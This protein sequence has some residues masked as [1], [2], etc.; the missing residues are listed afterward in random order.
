MTHENSTSAAA[1]ES[2]PP[3]ADQVAATGAT[4]ART[5]VAQPSTYSSS[6]APTVHEQHY[7]GIDEDGL[8]RLVVL[9][10]FEQYVQLNQRLDDIVRLVAATATSS[11]SAS[12]SASADAD[13]NPGSSSSSNNTVAQILAHRWEP[14]PATRMV[15]EILA[16]DGQASV[17]EL[18]ARLKRQS[19]PAHHLTATGHA[20]KALHPPGPPDDEHGHVAAP[21][22][23]H[24]AS[25][26]AQVTRVVGEI[27]AAG[28]LDT[29]AQVARRIS[30]SPT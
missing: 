22:S 24:D 19:S 11:A 16:H 9:A 26:A 7:T 1:S 6:I 20:V 29:F 28:N 25:I 8:N 10:H 12:A 13:A 21:H 5:D 17:A 2:R 27:L 23:E 14:G 30:F 3:P 4:A 15:N 18:E